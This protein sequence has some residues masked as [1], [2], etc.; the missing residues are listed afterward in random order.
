MGAKLLYEPVHGSPYQP[1]DRVQVVQVVDATAD[2]N[3]VVGLSGTVIHLEY[4]CGSGQTFPDDPMIG[5]RLDD[6]EKQEFW[7]EE[8]SAEIPAVA[9][10]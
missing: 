9:Y 4:S 10:L 8:L 3:A 1:G 6:G 7:A 2:A 5:V